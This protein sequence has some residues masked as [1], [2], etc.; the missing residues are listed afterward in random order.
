MQLRYFCL[1]L[2]FLAFRKNSSIQGISSDSVKSTRSDS[3]SV[4]RQ[5]SGDFCEN[6]T[7][8]KY[9]CPPPAVSFCATFQK[10]ILIHFKIHV[11]ISEIAPIPNNFIYKSF[12]LMQVFD[13][14]TTNKP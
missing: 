4:S 13:L 10:G 5:L 3:I 2:N 14:T 8:I 12:I 6:K 9:D 1:L 7:D 11:K